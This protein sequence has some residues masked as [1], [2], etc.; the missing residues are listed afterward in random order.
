[1]F[2]LFYP[3]LQG[4]YS[5]IKL[6][7]SSLFHPAVLLAFGFLITIKLL[8]KNS[9]AKGIAGEKVATHFLNKLDRS[10]YRVINDLTIKV[11]ASYSQIDHIVV[12]SFGI[13]II[14]TKVRAGIVFGDIQKS[15]WTQQAGKTRNSFQNPV[16][17]ND[18]HIQAIRQALGNTLL[19]TPISIIAFSG[20]TE[21][22]ISGS[23]PNTH[24]IKIS[25]L[26]STIGAYSK[27]LLH[28]SFQDNFYSK[29]CEL[30]KT[31]RQYQG[32]QIKYASS[33][34]RD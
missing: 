6:L 15:N 3:L 28:R 33:R 4:L 24:I 32:E 29:L 25:Q 5:G 30:K 7:I 16:L 27:S 8:L 34:S 26:A 19:F 20:N 14:E 12:S 31:G 13:F 10:Q 1:M 22:R 17:Q 9:K 23:K 2:E 21:V 11:G 18:W